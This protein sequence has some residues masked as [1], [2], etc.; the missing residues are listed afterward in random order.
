MTF[1]YFLESGER[2]GLSVI[3]TGNVL[4]LVRVR[5]GWAAV[6]S[7]PLRIEHAKD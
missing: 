5:R 2:F 6:L 3:A 4:F 7:V 1:V